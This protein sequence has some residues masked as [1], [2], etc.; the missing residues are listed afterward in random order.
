MTYKETAALLPKTGRAAT[1]LTIAL[2]AVAL[3]SGCGNQDVD[4]RPS[5]VGKEGEVTILI[6][7]SRWNGA[8]GEALQAE[9]G[10]Y[11]GTLPAPERTFLINA[12]GMDLQ[13]EQLRSM[14]NIVVA[15]V[16]SDS[17]AESRFIR[18]RLPEGAVDSLGAND[19]IFVV[20]D[21]LWRQNQ[22]V[23]YIAATTPDALVRLV[24]ERGEDLR[25][26]FNE[27][28][29]RRLTVDMFKKGRQ[30]DLEAQLLN[31]HGFAVNVQHDFVIAM[32]TTNFVWLR[33]ILSDTWRSVFIYY[34]EDANP[35]ILSPEWIY[36]TRDSLTRRYIQ[37]NLGDFIQ[38]DYRRPLETET[39]SFLGRYGFESRGLWYMVADD[40]EGGFRQRSAMGGPFLTYTFYDE[41]SGRIYMIDGMVFAPGFDKREFLRQM[42]VIAYTFRTAQSDS[43]L[44]SAQP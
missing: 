17:S 40:E 3:W 8:V 39:V 7:S 34:I 37:G 12:A 10:S 27:I 35:Q 6:D 28:T 21:N 32:D 43:T 16:L 29:R 4:F 13:F 26:V 36:S 24:H 42:E 18:S 41:P 22:K 19:G 20:R 9:I 15:A 11:I 30:T 2:L 5:A 38:V 33:R 44:A 14:K 23:I 1:L 31:R 25:Y